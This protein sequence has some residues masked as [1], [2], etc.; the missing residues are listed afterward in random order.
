VTEPAARR[1]VLA[2]LDVLEQR[3]AADWGRA[4]RDDYP[5]ALRRCARAQSR[6]RRAAGARPAPISMAAA[7]Q[8]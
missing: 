1:Q 7:P 5:A 8:A 4:F 2:V 3:P 6:P